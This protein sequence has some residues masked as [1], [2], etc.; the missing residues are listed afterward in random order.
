[1]KSRIQLISGCE[2]KITNLLSTHRFL[3]LLFIICLLAIPKLSYA[4]EEHDWKASAYYTIYTEVTDTPYSYKDIYY[5]IIF[6][7]SWVP[8]TLPRNAYNISCA[9][10][11]K[12][13]HANTAGEYGGS[14]RR[15]Q[16]H[17]RSYSELEAITDR[18]L[19]EPHK[20]T[21]VFDYDLVGEEYV[22][23]HEF[24]WYPPP[25][26]ATEP[27]PA[28]GASVILSPGEPLELKWLTGRKATTHDVYFSDNFQDV[29]DGTED[30]FLGNLY[31]F[32]VVGTPE[33]DYTNELIPGK[34][35]YWRIDEIDMDDKKY[36]GNVWSFWIKPPI[37]ITDPNLVCWWTFD[38]S[39]CL[40]VID[41]SGH[42]HD[43]MISDEPQWVD[44]YDNRAL[45]FVTEGDYVTCSL[46]QTSDWPAGTVAFWIKADAVGQN[47]WSGVFSSYSASSAGIQIDVDGGNPGNYQVD[48]GGLTFGVITTDWIHLALT[49]EDSL[50]KLYYNG[51]WIGNGTL[52]DTKF[53]QFTMGID[54][55]MINTFFGTFD[56]LQI[57]DYALTQDEIKQV[58]RIKPMIAWDP[59]PANGS[60]P[61]IGQAMS[62]VWSPGDGA[63]QHDIYLGTNQSD[64]IDA[65]I[66][67]ASGIYRGR[68]D[69]ANYT[70]T[71]ILESGKTY[72]WR[73]DESNDLNENTPWKGDIWIFTIRPEIAYSPYPSDGSKVRQQDVTLSWIQ[74]SAGVFHDVY[75]GTDYDQV[76]GVD[77]SDS[78]GI[79]RGQVNG[80]I[81][82]LD[83]LDRNRNYYW[84]IDEVQDDGVTIHKGNVW[85][86]TV[87]KLETIE[88]QLSSSEDDGYASNDDLRNLSG[89]F[90]RVGRSEF[91]DLPYY[92][93]GMIFK[94]INIPRGTEIISAR[95]KIQSYDSS[96]TDIVYGKI[97]AEAADDAAGFSAFHS[98]G[99]LT[100]TNTSVDW[101]LNEPWLAN[102]WY[103]SPDITGVIQEVINRDGWQPNNS[104]TILYSTRV[105]EGGYR[106]FS[107]YDRS[108]DSAPT[109]EITYIP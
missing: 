66:S 21:I 7:L 83:Q 63:S 31:L 15:S 103:T 2:R 69:L 17:C 13:G 84:R 24:T 10:R 32:P 102:T 53:D 88:Y 106:D 25:L 38:L 71:E 50:A 26:E 14:F 41:W 64:V 16:G 46:D 78:S 28:E 100:M 109:L 52:K 8:P 85:S 73:I 27:E 34:T 59:S 79:Y 9:I 58:M 81:F 57:Y 104:L 20:F 37:E 98:M 77:N 80:T 86:F 108:S 91:S 95:L 6:T 60:V 107:S 97:A 70:P 62:L 5:E 82:T 40:Y 56:D 23:F 74:S 89:D 29:N 3:L 48:P 19:S 75:F 33:S 4:D 87:I 65:D 43:A 47:A 72:F 105:R 42:G 1:M 12:G 54:R 45:S 96:L 101:D 94:D 68:Q 36:Q 61:D 44:G 67:D 18:I 92:V 30:A 49:F 76:N 22:M 99:T 90:L 11:F 39:E 51:S 35:Y 93:S 55:N